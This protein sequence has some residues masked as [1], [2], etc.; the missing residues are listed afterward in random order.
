MLKDILSIS[1]KPGLYK[2]IG[3]TG[4]AIIVESLQDGRRSLVHD[5][6]KN[7]SLADI[8]LYAEPESVPLQ[9]VFKRISGQ[10]NGGAAISHKERESTIINYIEK[11]VPGYDSEKVYVS[12]MKKVLQ[13]YNILL[14]KNM[15]PLDKETTDAGEEQTGE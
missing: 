10:E 3:Q 2:K 4:R 15:L 14:E 5:T 6:A 12:D 11:I 9:E 7:I 1:G 13:W 8:S